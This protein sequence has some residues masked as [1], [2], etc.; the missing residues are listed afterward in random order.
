MRVQ[1]TKHSSSAFAITSREVDERTSVVAVEGELDLSS[2][3]NLKWTLVDQLA[4]GRSQL[5]LDL[6]AVTFMDSTALGVLIGVDR[7]LSHGERLAIACPQPD[8][9]KI[10]E[11]TGLYAALEIFQRLDEALAYVQGRVTGDD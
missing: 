3:P 10:F 1:G 5:V 4:A 7:N 2:A 11:L 9:A 8:V 6:T